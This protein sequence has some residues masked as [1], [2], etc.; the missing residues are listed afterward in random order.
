MELTITCNTIA[1]IEA[2][3]RALRSYR[4]SLVTLCN[5][6]D[7][8]FQERDEANQEASVIDRLVFREAL[9]I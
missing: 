9:S 3:C 4:A 2:V 5:D 1:E 8:P 7:R 6:M